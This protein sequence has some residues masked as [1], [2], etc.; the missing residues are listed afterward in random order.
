MAASVTGVG[1]PRATRGFERSLA[2]VQEE[3]VND[4]DEEM[5]PV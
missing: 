4:D 5:M 1:S 3:E 2:S